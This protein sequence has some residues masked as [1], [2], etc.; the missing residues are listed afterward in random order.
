MEDEFVDARP[1]CRFCRHSKLL[2][3]DRLPTLNELKGCQLKAIHFPMKY[4]LFVAVTLIK[5]C[6]MQR[7]GGNAHD[8][9]AAE[10]PV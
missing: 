10:I 2:S 9:N 5:K 4:S 6:E 3:S 8:E 1:S 7:M